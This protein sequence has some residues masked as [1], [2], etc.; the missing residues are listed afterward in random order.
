MSQ[1]PRVKLEL[2]MYSFSTLNER[3]PIEDALSSVI[4][5]INEGDIPSP[6]NVTGS[7]VIHIPN[8]FISNEPSD[9]RKTFVEGFKKFL[10]LSGIEVFQF[11][12]NILGFFITNDQQDE[13]AQIIYTFCANPNF[14]LSP[15]MLRKSSI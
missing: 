9:P 13:A 4:R 14:N 11:G 1:K 8:K 3:K 2:G 12:Y 15:I 5:A 10:R 7:L 6:A